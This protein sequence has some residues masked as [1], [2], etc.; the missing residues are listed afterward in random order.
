MEQMFDLDVQVTQT[1]SEKSVIDISGFTT[2]FC[3]LSTCVVP[4]Q[5]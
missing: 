4:E 3:T 5:I 2:G 1:V